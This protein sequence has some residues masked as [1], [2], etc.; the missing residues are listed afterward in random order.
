M[1]GV[2]YVSGPATI[3]W[4]R[5]HNMHAGHCPYCPLCV[6]PAPPGW[7]PDMLPFLPAPALPERNPRYRVLATRLGVINLV[8]EHDVSLLTA[9]QAR[10]RDM[11]RVEGLG[12]DGSWVAGDAPAV[13]AELRLMAERLYDER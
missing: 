12:W 4:V 3:Y 6:T 13:G 9:R 2:A 8:D 10:G 7:R 1:E 11:W 5:E